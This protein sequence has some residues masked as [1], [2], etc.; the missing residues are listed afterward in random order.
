MMRLA[1]CLALSLLWPAAAR[2]HWLQA[3]SPHFVVYADDSERNVRRFSDQLER[4]HSAIAVITGVDMPPP[5]PSN[6]VTVYVVGSERQVRALHGGDNRYLGGFY[7]PRAGGSLAIVPQVS[8]AGMDPG[9]SMIVLLHEYAHHFFYT[10]SSFPMPRWMSEGGA[11]FLASA[12]FEAGGRVQIGKPA[13]HR[14]AE[15]LMP[16]FAKDVAV[17]DL[18]DPAAYDKRRSKAYDAFYGK[19]WLLYHYLT[20][21]QSREGQLAKYAELL[22]QGKAGRDAGT[23]A[24]GDLG[25][26]EKDLDAYLAR[27]RM[28]MLNLPAEMLKPG[29][30]S[31]RQLSA[32][33]AAMMPVRIRSRRGV[34]D[35]EAQVLLAEARTIAAR[36]PN[37]PAVFAALAEA[38][39][40]AGNHAQAV[41]AAD[42]ALARDPAQVNAYVQK[43]LALF[44]LAAEA[45]PVDE[46]EAYRKALSPFL[47]LNRIENDHPLPLIYN[48]RIFIEQGKMP[49]PLAVAGL[50]RAAHLAP[51]DLGLRMTLAMQQ[52]RTGQRAKAR[53]NLTPVA[54]SPHGGGMAASAQRALARLDN[55]PR[56]DGSGLDRLD[57]IAT[58]TEDLSE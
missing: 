24:F 53:Y 58:P 21:E 39:H 50:E 11:E 44:E 37:D 7:V 34:D 26:L 27:R 32:G 45:K 3:S 29:S 6:R 25:Q 31:I 13:Q 40:D 15:L 55:D 54:Y 22:M 41:V 8:G 5:S 20:F 12:S 16:Q 52:I 47:Q 46:D 30:V 33:E 36:F 10:T 9:W 51:F 49:T 28:S 14:A 42:A 4:Y 48:Y 35:K 17:A 19:S 57:E 23:E 1:F 18:L 2:A 56:W 43:G 38:E